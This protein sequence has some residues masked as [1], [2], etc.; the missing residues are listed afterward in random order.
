MSEERAADDGFISSRGFLVHGVAGGITAGLA[1]AAVE[2]LL[3]V[4]L[5]SSPFRPFRA[6]GSMVLGQQ[7][8]NE[9]YP[10][11]AAVTTG[12]GLHF[13][14]SAIYGAIFARILWITGQ[15]GKLT[16]IVV[17]TGV[18][19]AL[20][21]WA[22]NFLVIAPVL[23]YQLVVESPFWFGFTIAHFFYGAV[24]GTYLLVATQRGSAE[25]GASAP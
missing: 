18:V 6:I 3:S 5:G 21:L 15:A 10:L 12:L 2:M 1:F 11:V 22:V 19:Y 25:R 20:A 13:L 24:L 8:L 17:A 9:S 7:A 4:L 16:S 14:L 23:F